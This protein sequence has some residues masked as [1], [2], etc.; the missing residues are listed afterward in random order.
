MP[1][2]NPSEC[3]EYRITLGTYE[4]SLLAEFTEQR[5]KEVQVANVM[6]V[7]QPVGLG[8]AGAVLG[9][10]IYRGLV[11]FEAGNAADL[12]EWIASKTTVPLYDWLV[13]TSSGMT[14]DEYAQYNADLEA[15]PLGQKSFLGQVSEF[16]QFM[17][18]KGTLW[19]DGGDDGVGDD[20]LIN[21]AWRSVFG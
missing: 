12:A 14:D 2:K 9:Y 8:V 21:M 13:Q 19:G 1:R 18:G 11:D 10:G 15:S 7:A 16:G 20:G 3:I 6:K 4:R 17:V 5:K